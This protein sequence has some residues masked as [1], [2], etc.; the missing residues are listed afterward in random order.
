MTDLFLVL[1]LFC[2]SLPSISSVLDPCA[3]RPN[4][5]QS[6]DRFNDC[7]GSGVVCISGTCR[8]HQ[9]YQQKNDPESKANFC[10]KLPDTINA[11]CSGSCRNPMFC[12][13]NK[14]VCVRS[15][16]DGNRCYAA[17]R[18]GDVCKSDEECSSP[19][20]FC[21]G[22]QCACGP[23]ASAVGGGECSMT[24]NCPTGARPQGKCTVKTADTH[25]L[26]NTPNSGSVWD[27]C[28][29]NSFCYAPHGSPYGVCCPYTC[30]LSNVPD[31]SYS[32]EPTATLNRCP[33]ATHRCHRSASG[34]HSMTV[35]C[36][37]PCREPTPVYV[38]GSCFPRSYLGSP[39]QINEQCDGGYGMICS[40][41][42]C[43]CN[44]GF[45]AFSDAYTTGDNP[46]Q[47]CVRECGSAQKQRGGECFAQSSLGQACRV[48]E[49]CPQPGSTC[50]RGQCFCDCRQGYIRASSGSGCVRGQLSTQAPLFGGGG[51]S[52]GLG[53]KTGGS[54]IPSGGT[55]G[56]P[57]LIDT[58]KSILPLGPGT[59]G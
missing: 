50:F 58:L 43:R 4:L 10:V 48:N 54:L 17:S 29:K 8:C 53:G 16:I 30:P 2:V 40:G 35:C 46:P 36:R 7:D 14:C 47:T 12:Q 33:D 44:S 23:G 18:V 57:S 9:N 27:S 55:G 28:S 34:S 59:S 42:I 3:G 52:G 31:T 20:S 32:C 22:G 5:G 39:C 24:P 51:K 6:C 26:Q 37:M 11:A 38:R 49:Q 1:L 19:F 21:R 41:G 15:K 45:T 13:G 25:I 56:S